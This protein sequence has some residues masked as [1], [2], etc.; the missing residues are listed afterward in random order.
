[1]Q[2]SEEDQIIAKLHKRMKEAARVN[3]PPI[4]KQRIATWH[5]SLVQK[6]HALEDSGVEDDVMDSIL[7]KVLFNYFKVLI[8]NQF[9][10]NFKSFLNH[11]CF[12]M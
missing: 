8:S 9:Q 4:A 6:A 11:F 7:E 5:E 1:M 10:I 12:Q 2:S 3:A